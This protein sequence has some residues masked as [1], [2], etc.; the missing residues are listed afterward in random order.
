MAAIGMYASKL[1]IVLSPFKNPL[2]HI[3]ATKV[4]TYKKC[5]NV[6][7]INQYGLLK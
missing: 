5:I 6:F 3:V 4:T 2:N 1:C 7:G